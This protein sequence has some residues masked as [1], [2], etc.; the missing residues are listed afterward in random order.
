MIVKHTKTQQ[1]S[2]QA[3]SGEAEEAKLANYYGSLSNSIRT[4]SSCCGF[5]LFLRF[6]QRVTEEK[7]GRM[8]PDAHQW[9]YM[10]VCYHE[11]PHMNI[12]N[13]VQSYTIIDYDILAYMIIYHHVNVPWPPRLIDSK[14]NHLP[15]Y[16]MHACMHAWG[17]G[18]EW[19]G[20]PH[21]PNKSVQHF[22]LSVEVRCVGRWFWA[23]PRF[24][25]FI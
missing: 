18:G 12:Y 13:H 17:G 19:P 2:N 5:T 25:E 22:L 3:K 15:S 14:S 24:E 20:L 8:H 10:I 23:L 9:W 11:W 16:D 1:P 4:L 6:S 21:P 7:M